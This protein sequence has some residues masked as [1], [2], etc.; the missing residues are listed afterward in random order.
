[1]Y[2]P[3]LGL[4]AASSALT[5]SSSGRKTHVLYPPLGSPKFLFPRRPGRA[6]AAA[7]S[8]ASTS[9]SFSSRMQRRVAAALARIGV[10]RLAPGGVVL[11]GPGTFLHHL[12]QVVGPNLV[13]SVHL[14]PPRANRKP[15]LQVMSQA[16]ETLAFAKLGVNEL[17]CRRV[18]AERD[19]LS[20]LAGVSASELVVPRLLAE[21]EWQGL[22]YLVMKPVDTA[23]SVPVT[24]EQA[25]RATTA[26][27]GAFAAEKVSIQQAAWWSRTQ[28]DLAGCV[29]NAESERLRAAAE[30]VGE[31]YGQEV[32]LCGA[33]HGDFSPWNLSA[34]A[35][36]L[37]V[38]DWERFALDVPVGWDQIHFALN[39]YP[40][41][42][43]AAL[44][45]PAPGL[46]NLLGDHPTADEA[47]LALTYLLSRGVSYV[48]DRQFEAGARHGPLNAWL[49]P[50]LEELIE[51]DPVA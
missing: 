15:V 45:P 4:G 27:V 29:D 39:T 20:R 25:A 24:P 9:T 50:T 6:S 7:V 44:T 30:T 21:G 14:G 42:A 2:E 33:G 12:E 3:D 36:H 41:G 11:G 46:R 34:H 40:G 18:R 37:V 38:W 28:A 17:T 10:A 26:L 31:R 48:A 8:A 23:S 5:L 49:L 51:R 13:V 35:Q 43:A 47:L 32:M 19:A 22:D 16:G 1:M